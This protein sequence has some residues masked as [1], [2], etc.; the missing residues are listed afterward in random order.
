MTSG[1]QSA[2]LTVFSGPTISEAFMPHPS[3]EWRPPAR[4]GDL[5][6]M[7]RDRARILVFI[8]GMFLHQPAPTHTEILNVL[9]SGVRLIGSASMGALR[10]A[11]LGAYGMIGVGV[12]Y[13]ALLNGMITD[14]AELGVAMSPFSYE[15][16]SIP[17]IEVRR[18]IAIA[19]PAL[20]EHTARRIFEVARNVHFME[21]TPEVLAREWTTNC[22]EAS[23]SLLALLRSADCQVKRA[24]AVEAIR[25]GLKLIDNPDS[26]YQAPASDLRLY[27]PR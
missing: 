13:R 2:K 4:K 27:V 14:D 15:A 19:R 5:A 10:A 11:D 16:L 24:D 8:D 9:E 21:R 26:E 22:R 25:F 20:S 3:I 7:A 23:G 18:A 12:A 6:S 1:P 17:L